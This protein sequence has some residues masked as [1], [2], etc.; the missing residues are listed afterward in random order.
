M[1]GES[2]VHTSVQYLSQRV[3]W[4][5][6]LLI[7]TYLKIWFSFLNGYWRDHERKEDLHMDR[8]KF[9]YFVKFIVT[10]NIN[11][12][13]VYTSSKWSG[14]H[15]RM[16]I[17]RDR[18]MGSFENSGCALFVT[19]ATCKECSFDRRLRW[20]RRCRRVGRL[21]IL[22][23]LSLTAN[24]YVCRRTKKCADVY[25]CE[26]HGIKHQAIPETLICDCIQK[27]GTDIYIYHLTKKII[28]ELVFPFN[29]KVHASIS[30]ILHNAKSVS[31][32]YL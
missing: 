15:W 7:L 14:I 11:V 22:P 28:L 16:S 31:F 24:S 4:K 3:T 17:G 26:Y 12:F 29:N 21:P 32:E 20:Y 8:N 19:M 9:D 30:C 27:V 23:T 25:Y 6:R 10:N 13:L 5:V 1:P 18:Y 2:E